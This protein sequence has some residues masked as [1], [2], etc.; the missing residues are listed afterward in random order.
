MTV[1]TNIALRT[2][3]VA[4]PASKGQAVT[5]TL[6][7]LLAA[8]VEPILVKF[9]YQTHATPLQFL[10]LKTMLAAMLIYPLTR[11]WRWVGWA[12]LRRIAPVSALL[13]FT[14]GLMLLGLLYASVVTALTIVTSTPALVALVNRARGRE[15]HEARFWCGF[16]LSAGGVVLTIDLARQGGLSA[17]WM[18]ILAL[19]GAVVSST[20]YR[21]AME[22]LTSRH[23]PLLISTYTYFINGMI[24]FLFLLPWMGHVPPAALGIGVW[25]G[26]AGALANVAF[27]SALHLVGSTRISIFNMLQ[28]PLVIVTAALVF[29]E[30]LGPLQIVGIVAVLVGVRLARV[31]R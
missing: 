13:L 20:I 15:R 24:V 2:P 10:A 21:T 26:L 12:E 16:I 19:G 1:R 28:R 29:H 3:R 31:Q 6:L 30:P 25:I 23:P 14:N 8:D 5:W 18:G 4:A 7:A 27:I 17:S 9:G 11:C 22:D